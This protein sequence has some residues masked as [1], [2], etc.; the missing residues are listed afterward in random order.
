VD[1]FSKSTTYGMHPPMTVYEATVAGMS[2]G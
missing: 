2:L 1:T